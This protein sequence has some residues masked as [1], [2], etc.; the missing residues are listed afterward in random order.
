[1][2]LVMLSVS[3]AAASPPGG[4]SGWADAGLYAIGNAGST[5][6]T[7][8]ATVRHNWGGAAANFNAANCRFTPTN[9]EPWLH[10]GC[11]WVDRSGNGSRFTGLV[12]YDTGGATARN[13]AFSYQYQNNN[14]HAWTNMF[15]A[16]FIR[17]AS[18]YG[19]GMRTFGGRKDV[20]TLGPS[21]MTARTALK[22]KSGAP[23]F[24]GHERNRTSTSP[25]PFS[26]VIYDTA[27]AWNAGTRK[28]V[29]PQ[30][31]YYFVCAQ[32]WENGGTASTLSTQ[33][34]KNNDRACMSVSK[35]QENGDNPLLTA[36]SIIKCDAGDELYVERGNF[37]TVAN[38]SPITFFSIA[39][40]DTHADFCGFRALA[41]EGQAFPPDTNNDVFRSMAL[42]SVDY[43]THSGYDTVTGR[44]TVPTTG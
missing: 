25:I 8:D 41:G 11:A 3:G 4:G 12:E 39:H 27:S 17:Q 22:L 28:Y 18:G 29:V 42:A 26:T 15:G 10:L 6:D 23:V 30:D 37:E 19:I 16:P 44:Y 20:D 9:D 1:M 43:D 32:W 38:T 35:G 24:L 33:I 36:S 31:G 7:I 40:L 13:I 2:P 21:G 14:Y 5:S 34:Y